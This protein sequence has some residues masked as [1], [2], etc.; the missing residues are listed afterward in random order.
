MAIHPATCRNWGNSCLTLVKI[1]T[2]IIDAVFH[3]SIYNRQHSFTSMIVFF[4]IKNDTKNYGSE[5]SL[6][7]SITPYPPT[8]PFASGSDSLRGQ[9]LLPRPVLILYQ[10]SADFHSS[11]LRVWY[12]GLFP[13]ETDSIFRASK[14]FL[15][16]A[17]LTFFPLQNPGPPIDRPQGKP[18]HHIQPHF[19]QRQR[20]SEQQKRQ[21]QSLEI[22]LPPSGQTENHK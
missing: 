2:C 22:V 5:K 9:V 12:S 10:I 11:F 15:N 13:K 1:Y 18:L 14:F 19:C 17:S 7:K 8:S 3:I 6:N 20:H 21:K 16:H 4:S